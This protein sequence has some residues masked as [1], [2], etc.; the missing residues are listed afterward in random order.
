[1]PTC[2]D[3]P[4]RRVRQAAVH[5]DGRAGGRRLPRREEQHRV[6]HVL[7]RHLRLQQVPRSGSTPPGPA[8]SRPRASSG[9]ARLPPTGRTCR[10]AV[11]RRRRRAPP[12]SPARRCPPAPG[13]RCA[14]AGAR[15]PWW[16]CRRRTWRPARTR[17]SWT[18]ARCR[19]PCPA[20]GSGARPRPAPAACLRRSRARAC[21]RPRGPS[22]ASGETCAMPAL[23]ITRSTPP[24][25]RA[26]TAEGLGD[27]RRAR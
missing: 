18:P 8:S 11:A 16:R 27:R 9:R 17:S 24:Q 4:R 19:R 15:P 10:P 14:P 7:G 1:M 25:V 6:G 2:S 22:S 20:G 5:R 23:T 21:G 12:C 3:L 26:M 13:W